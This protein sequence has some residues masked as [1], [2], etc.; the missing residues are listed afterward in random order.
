MNR[1]TRD[2][3]HGRT[4]TRVTILFKVTRGSN[5]WT[6]L[7]SSPSSGGRTEHVSRRIY[8]SE[9]FFLVALIMTKSSRG[10]ARLQKVEGTSRGPI[11]RAIVVTY[12]RRERWSLCICSRRAS[13]TRRACGDELY[14]EVVALVPL[15]A[16]F[17]FECRVVVVVAIARMPL[18]TLVY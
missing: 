15:A 3:C 6:I 14:I 13:A 9:L 18:I 16:D 17:Y 8:L 11:S 4:L 7:G 5:S 10:I 2:T 12:T 1:C